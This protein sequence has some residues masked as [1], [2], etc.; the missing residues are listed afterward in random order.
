MAA[1]LSD[2]PFTAFLSVGRSVLAELRLGLDVARRALPLPLECESQNMLFSRP[3]W[4][5]VHCVEGW[6]L[7]SL[8]QFAYNERVSTTTSILT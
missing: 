5:F 6:L 1:A 2:L 7:K 3:R 4:W 8:F